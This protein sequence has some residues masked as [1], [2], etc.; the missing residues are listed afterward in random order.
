M[1]DSL[2]DRAFDALIIFG[3]FSG[4]VAIALLGF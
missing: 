2:A 3:I 4:K 1:A